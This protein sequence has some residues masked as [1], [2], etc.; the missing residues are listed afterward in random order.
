MR[1]H[2]RA[3]AYMSGLDGAHQGRRAQQGLLAQQRERYHGDAGTAGTVF[4]YGISTFSPIVGPASG[5]HFTFDS[6]GF[7]LHDT[8]F[9]TALLRF[10]RYLLAGFQ[11]HSALH[12][13]CAFQ[14]HCTAFHCILDLSYSEARGWWIVLLACMHTHFVIELGQICF[15][16]RLDTLHLQSCPLLHQ[17]AAQRR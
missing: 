16:A 15:Y 17:R 14:L 8:P 3:F 6:S 13:L 4:F 1:R 12:G 9:G 2:G 5:R 10:L 11:G 7:P